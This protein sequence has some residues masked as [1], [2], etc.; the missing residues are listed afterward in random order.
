MSGTLIHTPLSSDKL[1]CRNNG[2]KHL[3][4]IRSI[5]SESLI[6]SL[7]GHKRLRHVKK[8]LEVLEVPKLT[9]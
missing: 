6:C 5:P 8:N 4:I 9:E 2:A 3:Q 1:D 7:I